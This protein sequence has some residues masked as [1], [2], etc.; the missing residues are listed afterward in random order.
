[1]VCEVYENRE[2]L[3][4]PMVYRGYA[5]NKTGPW[6]FIAQCSTNCIPVTLPVAVLAA[7]LWQPAPKETTTLGNKTNSDANMNNIIY[8]HIY[9]YI[10]TC[11]LL[12]TYTR[13][14]HD[15]DW[16]IHIQ[17][18]RAPKNVINILKIL[19]W[20][21]WWMF[22][23]STWRILP[24]YWFPPPR[25]LCSLRRVSRSS[26]NFSSFLSWPFTPAKGFFF[27]GTEKNKGVFPWA[28]K[29]TQQTNKN[30]PTNQPTNKTNKQNQNKTNKQTKNTNKPTNQPTNKQTS[31]QLR[32]PTLNSKIHQLESGLLSIERLFDTIQLLPRPEN[33]AS[34]PPSSECL[35][36]DW[37][38]VFAPHTLSELWRCLHLF[39][40]FAG[41]KVTSVLR[42]QFCQRWALLTK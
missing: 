17:K 35:S 10:Y 19:P 16:E 8:V 30:K 13:I 1:M 32:I 25:A 7:A 11:K 28:N 21:K 36:S 27:Q 5:L 38:R 34:Q 3:N 33:Q 15:C 29:Q 14:Y 12:C 26:W 2:P 6:L 31:K 42:S 22:H 20:K 4:I 24:I 9:I 41:V 40:C 18:A 37:T 23:S 39:K